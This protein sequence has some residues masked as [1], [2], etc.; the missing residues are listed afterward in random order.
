MKPKTVSLMIGGEYRT[1]EYSVS[2]V[3]GHLAQ[4][5]NGLTI[6]QLRE[7]MGLKST[8]DNAQ[9]WELLRLLR[10]QGWVASR[11]EHSSFGW[12]HMVFRTALKG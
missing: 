12:N 10:D 8:N 6:R 4:N 11:M 7:R 5:P 9:L 2:V 3:M 1:H